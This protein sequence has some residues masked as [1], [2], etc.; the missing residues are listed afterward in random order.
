MKVKTLGIDPGT[1]SIGWALKGWDNSILDAGVVCF[2]E[3][4][5]YKGDATNVA[6]R[7]KRSARRTTTRKKQRLQKVYN[8]LK[9]PCEFPDKGTKEW[10][11]YSWDKVRESR[12]KALDE[13]VD[14]H[15]FGRAIYHLLKRR[16][17]RSN[18]RDLKDTGAVRSGIS[19]LEKMMEESNSRT[20]GE[21][22]YNLQEGKTD[23]Q[24]KA[25]LKTIRSIEAGMSKLRGRY[26]SRNM[27][28]EEFDLLWDTQSKHYPD[29][30]TPTLKEK[31]A[32][33]AFF[34]RDFRLPKEKLLKLRGRCRV[35]ENE[36]VAKKSSWY[37]Q[38]FRLN[39][40]L[41][42]LRYENNLEYKEL[43]TEQKI[44]VKIELYK[45]GSLT[46]KGLQKVLELPSSTQ[47]NLE[48]VLPKL[49]G[50]LTENVFR[51][52]IEGWSSLSEES[53]TSIRDIS[54][55]DDD[56]G[57]TE[58]IGDGVE[59][60][61][62]GLED[63]QGTGSYS[64]KLLIELHK[65][66][67]KGISIQDSLNKYPTYNREG[68]YD[69]LPPLVKAG[70]PFD[71]IK[72]PAV[73][74]TL[75]ELRKLITRLASSYVI[76]ENTT[77]IIEGAGEGFVNAKKEHSK[78]KNN[79][80]TND[81]ARKAL[82][83]IGIPANYKN[84]QK[85]NLWKEQGGI[86]VYS[87]TT[88]SLSNLFTGGIDVDHIYPR[89]YLDDSF[90]NKVVSLREENDDK[91]NR[92]PKEWLDGTDKYAAV[93]QRTKNLAPKKKERFLKDPD[94]DFASRQLNDT[95]YISSL[96]KDYLRLLKVKEVKAING[97]ITARLRREWGVG[98]KN[99]DDL[100]HHAEDAMI[101][102]CINN[103]VLKNLENEKVAPPFQDF[104]INVI[105]IKRNIIVKHKEQ[106]R[107][108]GPLH[109]ETLYKN[110]NSNGYT[111]TRV[112]VEDI[113]KGKLSDIVDNTT[114]EI[115]RNALIT[116]GWKGTDAFEVKLPSLRHKSGVPI[117]KITLKRNI[118][119]HRIGEGYYENGSNHSLYVFRSKDEKGKDTFEKILYTTRE[120]NRISRENNG[121]VVPPVRD[122][123]LIL[124]ICKGTMLTIDTTK[125]E[126]TAEVLKSLKNEFHEDQLKEF[127][128]VVRGIT[129]SSSGQM[130]VILLPH[131][132][133]KS[134]SSTRLLLAGDKNILSWSIKPYKSS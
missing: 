42:N 28:R 40:D 80:E 113:K 55:E 16:G 32:E 20:V 41:D 26:K 48:E 21:L 97:H 130:Q 82:N 98:P 109:K 101:L 60:V 9:T 96:M 110:P 37:F 87:G 77:I 69:K 71:S 39:K 84:V 127:P 125:I 78:N 74:R 116:S 53:K 119:T 36:P 8:L 65:N 33:A 102:A 52:H 104:R 61:L 25:G 51:D 5:T 91:G 18:G 88:I 85:Y 105:S 134:D 58:I 121:N 122:S 31:V 68:V 128:F 90:N 131:L 62:N 120:A 107:T 11:N 10:D 81:K 47:F 6:R 106:N 70:Y 92:T 22:E 114:R 117:D 50:N 103:T 108:R 46:W 95:R 93:L 63:I 89:K 64:N 29:T 100:R 2:P 49:E 133:S 1:A 132:V 44:R 73:S 12:Y 76:D 67:E 54:S 75:S 86:C 45:K 27:I 57:L 14:L 66:Y 94:P 38:E 111:H 118:P 34:Q 13:K 72:N 56:E 124:S 99:R 23:L 115:V 30:L 83:E 123:E 17:Y 126:S 7:I 79:R 24:A 129:I 19:S 43:T 4:G 59:N 35:Y 3:G 112:R 15:D